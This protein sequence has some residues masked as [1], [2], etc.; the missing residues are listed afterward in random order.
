MHKEKKMK[1]KLL[2][3]MGLLL[4][5]VIAFGQTATNRSYYVRADGNDY[6]NNG[7]SEEKPFKTLRNAVTHA[8][9]GEITTITVIG[10]V[11]GCKIN[12]AVTQEITITGKP[13]ASEKEKAIIS[14]QIDINNSTVRFAHVQITS[15]GLPGLHISGKSIV[16][17]GTGARIINCTRET[18]FEGAGV[19]MEN[20]TLNMTDNAAISGN[21]TDGDGNGS[22]V[23]MDNSTLNMSG[24][25]AISGNTAISAYNGCGDGAGIYMKNSTLNMSNNA[26]VSGNKTEFYGH[27]CGISSIESTLNM[28]GNAAISGN[29][30]ENRYGAGGISLSY[31]ILNMSGNATISGNTGGYRSGC[32][33]LSD[34]VIKGGKITGNNG[35]AFGGGIQ[36][37]GISMIENVEISGNKA[38]IGAG[39]YI[40]SGKL[41]ISGCK[42]KGNEAR[43][44]GGGLFIAKE[45]AYEAINNAS[46]SDNRSGYG[47]ND[48]VF[49]SKMFEYLMTPW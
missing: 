10:A 22:G 31:S 20:S 14:S 9:Y 19:R 48:D 8:E 13:D 49:E 23:Y 26:T 33:A 3:I 34:S 47:E 46:V 30:S 1:K 12:N 35:S 41:T 6:T 42:I 27:A 40:A 25:A 21:T 7:R 15:A 37:H 5:A 4:I 18:P 45:A 16:T 43:F 38:W 11:N 17:L 36:S 2:L 24:D 28:S 39:V 29:T 32:V 44:V